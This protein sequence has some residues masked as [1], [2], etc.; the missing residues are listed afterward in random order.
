MHN[1]RADNLTCKREKNERH[2]GLIRRFI[3]KEKSIFTVAN[4]TI[5][6]VYRSFF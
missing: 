2:N 1:N 5:S 3:P 6:H 4:E